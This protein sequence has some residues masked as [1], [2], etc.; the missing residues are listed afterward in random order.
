MKKLLVTLAMLCVVVSNAQE[1]PAELKAQNFNEI[2]LNGM[3]LVLG[4]LELSYER[5]L[6]EESAVGVSVF[7]PIDELLDVNYYVSPYYRFYFGQKYAGGFF[8]EGFGMLNSTDN[9]LSDVIDSGEDNITDFA[10]GIGFGGKWISKR[11]L[12][13]ELNF[14]LGRNLFNS[15]DILNEFVFKFGI[16]FGYRF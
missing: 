13:G 8:L 7:Y 16:T 15:D 3:L 11:G 2:K 4:G 14:G 10:L 5:T 6:N 9:I 1:A 12:L